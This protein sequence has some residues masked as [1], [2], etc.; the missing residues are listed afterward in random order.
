M[1]KTLFAGLFSLIS[2]LGCAVDDPES[3]ALESTSAA[4]EEGD[5]I[6]R[7]FQADVGPDDAP[8]CENKSGSKIFEFGECKLEVTRRCEL[9]QVQGH[10]RCCCKLE[11][12][13]AND[14]CH[15]LPWSAVLG[16]GA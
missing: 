13:R 15:G 2:A 7:C 9:R 16:G 14:A 10:L 1:K 12:T 3:G 4:L 11:V 8:K 5:T 6:V